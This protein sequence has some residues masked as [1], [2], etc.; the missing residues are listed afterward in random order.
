MKAHAQK[1]ERFA[2]EI[3][4]LV[5]CVEDLMESLR[6]ESCL[7][8][9]D[10]DARR[11]GDLLRGDTPGRSLTQ[12][13]LRLTRIPM[14]FAPTTDDDWRRHGCRLLDERHP[15]A[16]RPSDADL[17]QVAREMITNRNTIHQCPAPGPDGMF[18]RSDLE[19]STP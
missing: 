2:S 16:R 17:E 4:V 3:A 15:L 1:D 8:S 5:I 12:R 11:I 13:I 18:D 19:I 14:Y 9:T 7:P 10:Q 6:R